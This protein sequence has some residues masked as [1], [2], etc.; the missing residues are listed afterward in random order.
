M[1]IPAQVGRDLELLHG[2]LFGERK[3]HILVVYK[4]PHLARRMGLVLGNHTHRPNFDLRS[5]RH[6]EEQLPIA[7]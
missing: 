3:V 1:D 4:E 2:R 5:E 6:D 7:V